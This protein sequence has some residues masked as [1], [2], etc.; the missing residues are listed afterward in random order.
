MQII[1]AQKDVAGIG[2]HNF[3]VLIGDNGQQKGQLHGWQIKNGVISVTGVGGTLQVRDTAGYSLNDPSVDRAVI[4]EGDAAEGTRLWNI[5]S[6]C[7]EK[8]NELNYDYNLFDSFGG[9]NSNA[10]ASTL[11]EC[12]E[13]DWV[14]LDGFSPGEGEIIIDTATMEVIQAQNP[15]TPK[16]NQP[17]NPGSI[18]DD[19]A[20]ASIVGV[21][22]FVM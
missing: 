11:V 9:H 4:W 14:D 15:R 1:Q 8:I 16:E 2:S 5:A 22:Q 6:D 13:L 3:L 18:P 12:M 21:D 10:A 7:G 20:F 19:T 17:Y